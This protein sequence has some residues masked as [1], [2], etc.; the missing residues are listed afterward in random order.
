[1]G[2]FEIT[3]YKLRIFERGTMNGWWSEGTTRQITIYELRFER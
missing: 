3:I 2:D 1:M